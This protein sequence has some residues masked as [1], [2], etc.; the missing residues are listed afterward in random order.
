MWNE[1]GKQYSRVPGR[2]IVWAIYPN[3]QGHSAVVLER[4]GGSRPS[5]ANYKRAQSSRILKIKNRPHD[6]DFYSSG[7]LHWSSGAGT[8]VIRFLPILVLN[9]CSVWEEGTTGTGP[10]RRPLC[11]GWRAP[12]SSAAAACPQGWRRRPTPT[13]R[14]GRVPPIRR[15]CSTLSLLLQRRAI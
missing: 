1:I 6:A 5:A 3:N 10:G 14:R 12:C 15:A 2:L 9:S 7:G 4:T 11:A 8:V 13:L